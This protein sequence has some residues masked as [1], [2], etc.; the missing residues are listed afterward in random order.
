M[1]RRLQSGGA[2]GSSR[3]R[4]GVPLGDSLG[5]PDSRGVAG[6]SSAAG[7]V[8]SPARRPSE[9][10]AAPAGRDGGGCSPAGRPSEE[11]ICSVATLG[12]GTAEGWTALSAICTH[13]G[14]TVEF[15]TSR[16]V[17][18]CHGATFHKDGRVMGGP[19]N[20]PLESY[21][22]ARSGDEIWVQLSV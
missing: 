6:A 9:E 14:C 20:I 12:T 1:R 16:V 3:S 15:R 8:S 19:T 17:C 13:E 4:L 11:E 22:A 21:P 18:P 10:D 2:V 5:F 7:A